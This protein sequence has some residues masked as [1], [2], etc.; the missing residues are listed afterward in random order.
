[1]VNCPRSAASRLFVAEM[2]DQ[3]VADINDYVKYS[4]L[5]ALFDVHTSSVLVC[6]MLTA[7]DDRSDGRKISY[8]QDTD[9]YRAIDPDLFDLLGTLVSCG[10]RTTRGVELLGILP[11]ATYFRQ[12]LEDDQSGRTQFFTEMWREARGCR[13]A[14]FDPDNGLSVASVPCGSAGSRRYIYCSDLTPL[15]ELNAAAV[16]YQHFPRVPRAR[17]V[18]EQLDR[19]ATALPGFSTLAI[20]SPQVALLA[21]TPRDQV[22][23]FE[24]AMRLAAHRWAGRLKV[25]SSK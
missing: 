7:D 10:E 24:A 22:Q 20:Y 25:T 9:R 15:Q 16:L 14:F 13:V 11:G 2:K 1:M 21:A 3:Y 18:A 17:Y 23:G 19:L 5:R 8:L 6:W 12:R 4:V